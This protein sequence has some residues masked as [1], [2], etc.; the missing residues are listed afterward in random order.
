MEDSQRM[1][2]SSD[3]TSVFFFSY[4]FKRKIEGERGKRLEN[5]AIRKTEQQ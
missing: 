3:Q 4:L 2:E 1:N 5:A